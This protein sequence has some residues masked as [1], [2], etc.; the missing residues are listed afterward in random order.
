MRSI[1]LGLLASIL[2][3][4]LA[5]DLAARHSEV[6]LSSY[7]KTKKKI[8]FLD[9]ARMKNCQMGAS[10]RGKRYRKYLCGYVRLLAYY[11]HITRARAHTKYIVISQNIYHLTTSTP[12]LAHQRTSINTY[13]HTIQGHYMGEVRSVH[14]FATL[15]LTLCYI[16]SLSCPR[17][18]SLSLWFS[19]SIWLAGWL[20][21]SLSLALSLTHT[22]C[23]SA[24]A[25]L[26]LALFHTHTLTAEGYPLTILIFILL[27]PGGLRGRAVPTA[28]QEL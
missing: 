20:A 4:L 21:R 6:C 11:I 22:C 23:S 7:Q 13:I 10:G 24:T 19:L 26:A 14:V 2:S 25:A 28:T 17:S 9:F 27:R 5:T 3:R 1:R 12:L 16:L 15:S 18:L 8:C